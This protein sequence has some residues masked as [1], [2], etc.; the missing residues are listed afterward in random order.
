MF[1]IRIRV[2]LDDDIALWRILLVIKRVTRGGP[3]AKQQVAADKTSMLQ[4]Q[5]V[6][7]IESYLCLVNM[8]QF[9]PTHAAPVPCS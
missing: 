2:V 8:L 5:C 6:L 7:D 3:A 4:A 1:S 9:P